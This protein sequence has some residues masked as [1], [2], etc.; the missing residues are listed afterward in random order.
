MKRA[1]VGVGNLLAW[2]FLATNVIAQTIPAGNSGGGTNHYDLPSDVVTDYGTNLWLSINLS[3]NAVLLLLH[4]TQPGVPYLIQSREDL[5]SGSWSDAG[6]VTGAVAA[7]A[8]QARLNASGP[9]KSLFIQAL[10]WKTNIAGTTTVM[11]AIGGECIMK[12]TAN[13]DV[14]S[15]GG[16]QYGE[17]GDYTFLDSTNPVHVAGLTNIKK[18]A[19]GL[20]HSLALGSDGAVWAWGQNSDG[21]LGDGGTEGTNLPV[22]VRG[23]T[24]SAIAVAGG[25]CHSAAV[26]ADGMVWTWGNNNY[27]Q[28][29]TGDM[30]NTR[31]PVLVQGLTNA[32]AVAAGYFHTVVLLNNGTVW[33]W[34]DD[35]FNQLGD[36]NRETSPTPARVPGLSNIVAICAAGNHNLALDTNGHVWAWGMNDVYH[37]DILFSRAN[38]TGK[39]ANADADDTDGWPAM[40]GGLTN[41]T[42]IAAGTSHSLALDSDGSLWAW[43]RNGS[44][45]LG[46][47]GYDDS[48]LP[49]QVLGVTNIVSIAAGSDASAALDGN[50]NLWQWGVSDSSGMNWPWGDEKEL[51]APAP[52]YADFYNGQLPGL[53][54]LNG[55]NQVP[56]AGS[57]FPQ[58]LVFKVTDAKGVA[59]SN[60]PV[61]VEDCDGRHGIAKCQR[62]GRL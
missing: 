41:V 39:F 59:L 60:A 15:W 35:S 32:V 56:H 20:N 22:P 4:N 12:L 17:L 30:D 44:G 54:I 26:S 62:R 49:M 47:G 11:T 50:G 24:N 8:T 3:N 5:A 31:V 46:V 36:G 28:L 16:N 13:G 18:I 29:G 53:Q 42:G 19:S 48:D 6:T 2:I 21:Q 10:T 45:Q 34:G 58:P 61:S 51:P 57:E 43:G 55:N 23:M 14:I 9:T 27:G 33:A 7:T 40:V 25:Y 1:W 38:I 37:P 52:R